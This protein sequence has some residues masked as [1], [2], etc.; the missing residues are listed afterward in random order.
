MSVTQR[1]T[2]R[3]CQ[4][5]SNEQKFLREVL[6][7]VYDEVDGAASRRLA[8]QTLDRYL[9]IAPV[10]TAHHTHRPQLTTPGQQSLISRQSIL[11]ITHTTS[12]H[13]TRPTVLD[14]TPVHTAHHTH[15]PQL[16]TPGQQS[17][18]SRQSILHI[19]HTHNL[20]SQHQANSP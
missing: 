18:I 6:E 2:E 8:M 4:Y 1:R 12:T 17:L 14:I 10:H 20:N 7:L 16:T 19:T 11:H 13:N 15:R 3:V 9:D 5:S